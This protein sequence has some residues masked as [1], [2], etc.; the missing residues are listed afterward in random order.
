MRLGLFGER[1][2]QISDIPVDTVGVVSDVDRI[3]AGV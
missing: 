2:V 3:K 1:L